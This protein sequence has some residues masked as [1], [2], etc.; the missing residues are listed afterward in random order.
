MEQDVRQA[1]LAL[2]EARAR[3]ASAEKEEASAREALRVAEVRYQAEMLVYST[4]NS[5]AE[6][7]DKLPDDI[8][9]E[10][11]ES[12]ADVKTTLESND[13]AAITTARER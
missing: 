3:I 10:V 4:E 6:N 11:R 13:T 1:Q 7:E 2:A 5:L 9:T 12:L 8:K